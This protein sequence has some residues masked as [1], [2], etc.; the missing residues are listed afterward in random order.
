MRA[1]HITKFDAYKNSAELSFI[2]NYVS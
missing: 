2:W 1:I